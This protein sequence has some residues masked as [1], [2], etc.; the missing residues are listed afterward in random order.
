MKRAVFLLWLFVLPSGAWAATNCVGGANGTAQLPSYL[1]GSEFVDGQAAGSITPACMRDFVAT[2][3]ALRIVTASGT[4]TVTTADHFVEV[5]KA[6]GAATTVSLPACNSNSGLQ[7]TI[8][9]GK[10]DANINN[11]T[12]T[13]SAGNINGATTFVM[14]VSRQS[15]TVLWDGSQCL[16]SP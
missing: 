3:N 8:L 9:D 5:N 2:E 1:T 11:I 4:I 15:E 10:G 12:L 6:T 13:P 16:V 7:V 14:N